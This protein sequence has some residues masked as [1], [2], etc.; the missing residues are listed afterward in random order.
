MT[1][2]ACLRIDVSAHQD[3]MP[4][5]MLGPLVQKFAGAYLETRWSWPRR[6]SP[7][8]EF[9]FLLTDPRS[10][11][12][13]LEELRRLSDELQR[14]LFGVGDEGEV[15]LLVFEGAHAAVTAF[16]AM[17]AT[18][19]AAAVAD[20]S[21]LPPGG[22]LTRIVSGETEPE[23]EAAPS[24]RASA[25]PAWEP[26][27]APASSSSPAWAPATGRSRETGEPDPPP[28][29]A[30][31]GAQG[32]YFAPRE[33]FFGD[34]PTYIPAN[35]KTHFSLLDGPEHRAPDPRAFDA[36]CVGIAARTLAGRSKGAL[37]YVPICFD[38]L[39]RP[40]LRSLYEAMFATLPPGRKGE[41]AAAVY[42]VP[43]DPIF[44]GLKQARA[45]LDT[46]FS[47]VDLGIT[48]PGFQIEKLPPE[49]ATS[50]TLN[51]PDGDAHLRLS[52]LRRFAER[53]VH[54][55]QRRIWPGVSNIRRRAEAEAAVRLRIPFLTGPGVCTPVPSPVGGRGMKLDRLPM[56][57][58]AWMD[59]R[60]QA[61]SAVPQPPPAGEDFRAR[62]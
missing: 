3:L 26:A 45:F 28:A 25:G 52:S 14:H 29:T 60:D 34:V 27:T 48:D 51:L 16:A 53:L 42:D 32:V 6:F 31:E 13:D 47:V 54:Y 8:S 44:T 37:F 7:L 24:A 33:V 11:E 57:L 38:S 56:A 39:M 4:A 9:S 2:I 15:A 22:R 40:S 1:A 58:P 50:V 18:A 23:P 17:D 5:S 30:W 36:A 43:R 19:V 59:L 41:L 21:L 12:L 35:G 55:K 61:E 20:P 46:W 62:A 10:D 49:V